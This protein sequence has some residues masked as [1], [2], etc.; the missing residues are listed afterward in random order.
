MNRNTAIKNTFLFIASDH[1]GRKIKEKVEDYLLKL[2][3]AYE[4]LSISNSPN[5]DYPDF[6][7][8]VSKEVQSNKHSLGILVCGTGIGMSI[9]ANKFKG[10]RAA[11]CHTK[12]EAVL[13][14]EHNDANILVLPGPYSDSKLDVEDVISGFIF[15]EFKKGRH[16]KRLNKIKKIE[17]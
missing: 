2:S 14:R 1:A 13:A 4:D 8:S 5:D 3:L 9:S 16:L 10:I 11:L 6:A 12:K 17:S 15:S 7:R